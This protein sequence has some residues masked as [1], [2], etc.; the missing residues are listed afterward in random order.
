M[1]A[2]PGCIDA[3]DTIRPSQL[4]GR[5]VLITGGGSGFG[6]QLA[7]MCATAG[8][9]VV[10]GDLN[11][12]GL[13][14]TIDLCR[15]LSGS[16]QAPSET[17]DVTVE[18]SLRQLFAFAQATFGRP[19]DVV[20]ANAGITE[21]GRLSEDVALKNELGR[22]P[23]EPNLLTMNVNFSGVLLTAQLAEEAW[24]SEPS[25][26]H[27]RQLVLLASMGGHSGIPGAPLYSAS[28]HGLVGLW[29]AH[30]ARLRALPEP[31]FSCHAICPFFS[32]TGILGRA[33]FL[34]LAGLSVV[35]PETVASTVLHIVRDTSLNDGLGSMY[36]LPDH[37]EPLEFST[38]YVGPLN[39]SFYQEI[40]ETI[41]QRQKVYDD[42]EYIQ[43]RDD[44]I[45]TA[46]GTNRAD[47]PFIALL[48]SPSV[49]RMAMKMQL[50]KQ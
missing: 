34:A 46:I 17:S 5:S 50:L 26:E 48:V 31:T 38:D 2:V 20:V 28:K 21:V 39:H 33:V 30:C 49:A 44:E 40:T 35:Q 1:K 32:F 19:A 14:G 9:D 7:I 41:R 42:P 12:K 43:C 29:V 15:G 47:V 23:K 37:K 3:L 45:L 11:T 36:C 4:S 25:T 6:R 16:C 8:A 18:S 13:E 22:Y 10:I 24:K 27:N